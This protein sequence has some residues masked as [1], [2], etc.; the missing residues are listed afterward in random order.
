[1]TKQHSHH[2]NPN[3]L[4][5]HGRF[6]SCRQVCKSFSPLLKATTNLIH[7]IVQTS[8]LAVTITYAFLGPLLSLVAQSTL[9]LWQLCAC[10]IHLADRDRWFV[11]PA[12]GTRAQ[13]HSE[14]ASCEHMDINVI[15]PARLPEVFTVRTG[16]PQRECR[17]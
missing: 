15:G 16:L 12:T 8:Q 2:C 5:C 1:M 14:N 13:A 17:Q 7:V 6:R 4:L 9:F 10:H 11:H 3:R